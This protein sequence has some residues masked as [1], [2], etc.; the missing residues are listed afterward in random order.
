MNIINK[1]RHWSI[2]PHFTY[3]AL[4]PSSKLRWSL[5]PPPRRIFSFLPVPA[6]LLYWLSKTSK[7]KIQLISVDCFQKACFKQETIKSTHAFHHFSDTNIVNLFI[8]EC[9]LLRLVQT[10]SL[11]L[12][13]THSSYHLYKNNM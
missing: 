4:R 5:S 13:K 10:L 12:Y 2:L 8:H 7:N 11:I 6:S 9:K 3:N 1:K